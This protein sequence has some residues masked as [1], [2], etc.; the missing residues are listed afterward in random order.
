MDFAVEPFD[1]QITCMNLQAEINRKMSVF[2][3]NNQI[4]SLGQVE[5]NLGLLVQLNK[6]TEILSFEPST[7]L[8]KMV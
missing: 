6:I 5:F 4:F 2:I 8:L 7:N 1:F 3:F